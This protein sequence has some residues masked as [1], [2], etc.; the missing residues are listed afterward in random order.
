MLLSMAFDRMSGE[1][2]CEGDSAAIY[3]RRSASSMIMD[4][5]HSDRA[6][7]GK[8]LLCSGRSHDQESAMNYDNP[9]N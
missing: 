8:P 3:P 7:V 1:L 2:L 6:E 9:A 5:R 4:S